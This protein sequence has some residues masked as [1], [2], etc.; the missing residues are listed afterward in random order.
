MSIGEKIRQLRREKDWSQGQLAIKLG[1]SERHISRYENEKFTPSASTLKKIA[2]V[3]GVTIDYLLSCNNPE[4]DNKPLQIADIK[5]PELLECFL[6]ADEL[7]ESDREVVKKLVQAFVIKKNVK[8]LAK[9][10]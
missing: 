5:D 3:F 10:P 2:E 7:E 6:E 9:L 1:I 4:D 8:N